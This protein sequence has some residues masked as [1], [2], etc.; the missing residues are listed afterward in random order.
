VLETLEKKR[1]KIP[2]PALAEFADKTLQR[3]GYGSN[4]GGT[5]V[6]VNVNNAI[7]PQVS[8]EQL[9]EARAR[10]RAV[11]S[12]R[13]VEAPPQKQLPS[14]PASLLTSKTEVA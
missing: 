13:L 6:N 9:A 11:E 12:A 7:V 8:A 5:A 3:L 14:E 2:F 1:D 4:A 10:I